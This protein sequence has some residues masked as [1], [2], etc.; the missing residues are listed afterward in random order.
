M[1]PIPMTES[2]SRPRADPVLAGTPWQTLDDQD[3]KDGS[4]HLREGSGPTPIRSLALWRHSGLVF[5][6]FIGNLRFPH[7]KFNHNT[8]ETI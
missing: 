7:A 6:F 2:R 3:T 5:G 8:K 1:A 4:S